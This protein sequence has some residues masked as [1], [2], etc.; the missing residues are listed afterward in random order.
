MMQLDRA[1]E[2]Y[3]NAIATVK[4]QNTLCREEKL[5]ILL[6]PIVE[7]N[8][9]TSTLNREHKFARED[10]INLNEELDLSLLESTSEDWNILP[11]WK[12]EQF[13]DLDVNADLIDINFS[14]FLPQEKSVSTRANASKVRTSLYNIYHE[15]LPHLSLERIQSR[16]LL[17]Q[18]LLVYTIKRSQNGDQQAGDKLIS[19]YEGLASSKQTYEKVLKM[20][21][22]RE[23]N[24]DS[25][26]KTDFNYDGE[27]DVSYLRYDD[28]FRQNAIMYL[29][30]IIKGITPKTLLNALTG[31]QKP[32]TLP[33]PSDV[34]K[35]FLYYYGEYVPGIVSKYLD[36]H[37]SAQ[38]Y[39]KEPGNILKFIKVIESMTNLL[40]CFSLLDDADLNVKNLD[41]L[42]NHAELLR[43][44]QVMEAYAS[45]VPII[46]KIRDVI[47][48][49]IETLLDPY[50]PISSETAIIKSADQRTA[51]ILGVCYRPQKMSPRNN[52]T[53][54]LFG[55][56]GSYNL[57]KL[58]QM[59]A[60]YYSRNT[61]GIDTVPLDAPSAI[62]S[63]DDT[64][65]ESALRKQVI[66]NIYKIREQIEEA[67]SVSND[68]EAIM[69]KAN[70]T[71]EEYELLLDQYRGL[72]FNELSEKYNLTKDK[73]RYKLET[74]LNKLQNTTT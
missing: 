30:F 56:K 4:Q 52:L 36:Y 53:T 9:L 62:D 29:V 40:G 64:E 39:L 51:R 66:S 47:A 59:L 27:S 15:W 28:D 35:V 60:D 11:D 5:I 72:T 37:S 45:I 63:S 13:G 8:K 24:F 6:K 21:V 25:S 44:E 33:I 10:Y 16:S 68:L 31:R 58:N 23:N 65:E 26:K 70:V 7:F 32:T 3:F 73:V 18:I 67:A 20:L 2:H 46:I 55:G 49:Y 57:G 34:I 61:D 43:T 48:P 38:E 17:D 71:K 12:L 22:W 74:I 41:I 50:T 19:L 14:Y 54:W 1:I 69:K 42:K